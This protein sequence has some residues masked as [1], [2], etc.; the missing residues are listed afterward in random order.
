MK[1]GYFGKWLGNANADSRLSTLI[2]GLAIFAVG[3]ILRINF[4][5]GSDYP[6]ND[7]GFFYKLTEELINNHFLLPKYSQYNYSDIPFAY[8]PLAFYIIGITHKVFG[9]SLLALFRY[10]PLI[11]SCLTIPAFYLL[12]TRFFEKGLYRLLALYIFVTLPR[13]F[14]WFVMGGGATR[15]LGFLLAILSLYTLWG[16]FEDNKVGWKLILGAILSALTVLSHPL[17]SLFLAFSV[18]VIFIYLHPV[19]IKLL[20]VYGCIILFAASPWWL[21]VLSNHGISPFI[22]ASNTGHLNWFEIKNLITLN[23]GYE[24]PFF[25][26]IVSVLGIFGL[27]SK[28]KRISITLAILCVLGYFVIPRGGTDYLTAYLPMLAV[29]GFSVITE[30]WNSET[31][32]SANKQPYLPELKS[33]RTRALLVFIFVYLFLGGYTYKYVYNKG[34]LRLDE[35]NFQAMA[36]IR[37]HTQ[38]SD[39]VLLIPINQENRYW[40]N[41]FISEWLPALAQRESITTVQGYEWKPDIFEERITKYWSLRNCSLDF[42]CIRDWQLEYRVDPDLIYFDDLKNQLNLSMDF[43]ES[44]FYSRAYQN[45]NVMILE[46]VDH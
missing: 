22:G 23:F 16:A 34:D 19:K 7:G 31:L 9:V 33:R 11:I 28:R 13:S 25:L 42:R 18:I 35:S 21:S 41:D 4:I 32:P 45:S 3:I 17:S 39:T 1:K 26:A 8:P 38:D 29:I 12:S 44:G 10:F 43:L 30:P 40:W 46:K 6:L 36:W 2:F 5:A 20:F 37:D 27:F 24:N 15:S 14:E